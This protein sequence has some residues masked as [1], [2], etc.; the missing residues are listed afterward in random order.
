MA[1]LAVSDSVFIGSGR[2]MQGCQI[3]PLNA[4]GYLH[5]DV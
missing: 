4:S 5:F 1:V 3:S 2:S